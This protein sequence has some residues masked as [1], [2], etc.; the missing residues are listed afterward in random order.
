M[1]LKYF[2]AY[3]VLFLL[4]GF[5]NAE[6]KEPNFVGKWSGLTQGVNYENV[7]NLNEVPVFYHD[8]NITLDIVSQEGMVFAGY[9]NGKD[10]IT[11][12]IV[13]RTGN[14]YEVKMQSYGDNNR[15]FISGQLKVKGKI[16]KIIGIFNSFEEVSLASIPSIGTGNFVLT[17]E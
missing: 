2:I 6:P 3:V 14:T 17:K 7:L 8:E 9:L 12:A 13:K 15:N 16:M 11:G 1:K 10:M 4:C 5:A